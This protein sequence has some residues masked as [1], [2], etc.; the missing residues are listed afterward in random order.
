MLANFKYLFGVA[1]LLLLTSLTFAETYQLDKETIDKYIS[2]IDD[3]KN[4]ELDISVG[5]FNITDS[6]A[7]FQAVEVLGAIRCNDERIC[8][9][10]AR[11]K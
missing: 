5:K 8:K 4:W 3:E 7:L 1:I 9:A 10:L 6:D 11:K 2:I